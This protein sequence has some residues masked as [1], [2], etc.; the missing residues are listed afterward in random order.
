MNAAAQSASYASD[1]ALLGHESLEQRLLS[2]WHAGRMAHAYL[3][4]GRRG[5]GKTT[6]AYRLAQFMLNEA[7]QPEEPAGLFG[8]ALPASAPT[9]LKS[10][11]H[12]SA[13]LR[14]AA[15]TH[16]G[17]MF[18]QPLFDE[19]KQQFKDEISVDQ[20]RKI[21]AF[22]SQ[23]AGEGS[24]KVILIEPAEAMNTAAANALL[25]WLEEPPANTY[26]ILV[27]HNPSRLLPTIRSRCR[28]LSFAPLGM[29]QCRQILETKGLTLAD[30][31]MILAYLS[32]GS[33]G[34]LSEMLES[35]VSDI[36]TELLNILMM[37]GAEGGAAYRLAET[38]P[39]RLSW[40]NWY[41]LLSELAGLFIKTASGVP[42]P[43]WM[44]DA[45]ANAIRSIS[46]RLSASEWMA[47]REAIMALHRDTEQ[48]YL[49][50]KHVVMQMIELLAG[51]NTTV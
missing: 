43:E 12:S 48:L 7:E 2:E 17:F 3:F 19:K 35:Q 44:K 4:T 22:A 29:E 42:L 28:R 30:D 14:M 27:S 5:I 47:N 37:G 34:I 40:E 45:E 1:A 6:L 36:Y 33:V 11:P 25:K 9:L 50:R 46:E 31:S 49:D 15:G 41:V 10:N 39:K 24:K 21:T 32:G 18:L 8:D 16:S 26:F 20:V 23:T 38:L 51:K 13:S